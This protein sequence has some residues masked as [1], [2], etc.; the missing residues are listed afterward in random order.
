M[1]IQQELFGILRSPENY[2]RKIFGPHLGGL[3]KTGSLSLSG[4]TA[5]V[6]E[7]EFELNREPFPVQIFY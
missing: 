7:K 2:Q 4:L 5:P 3:C 6:C 1:S